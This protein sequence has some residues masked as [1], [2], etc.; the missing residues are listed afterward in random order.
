M[1]SL[2]AATLLAFALVP[3]VLGHSWIYQLRTLDEDGQY[4]G[5]YGYPRKFVAAGDPNFDGFSNVH[6]S[7]P[8]EQQPP[9]INK[10][11]PLCRDD[12][13]K[14]LQNDKYPRL[15]ANPGVWMSLRYAENGHTSNPS[16]LDG[17][18]PGTL[19]LGRRDLGGNVFIFGTTEPR[20]DEKIANVIQWTKDGSGGDKR[21]V[22]LAANDFDDGRCFQVNDSPITK[23]R[24]AAT[25][26]YAMGQ[27]DGPGTYELLCESN[28]QL[29]EDAPVGKP[30]TLY[31]VWQWAMDPVNKTSNPNPTFPNGKDE[32]YTTCMDV[33]VVDTIKLSTKA[34]FYMP[35]Q[36]TMDRAVP[37]FK[38]RK[39][40]IADPLEAEVGNLWK[41]NP[42]QTGA[43]PSPEPINTGIAPP[44]S[45]LSTIARPGDQP[46]KAPGDN[47][48]V[49][50][51]ET[52][53]VT[54]TAT[55]ETQ[56]VTARPEQFTRPNGAK[57]RGRFT[58]RTF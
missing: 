20:E 41:S 29:P 9:F 40:T 12:Q 56:R 50:I 6:L 14:P 23:K 49:T 47:D 15:Q 37:D 3:S 44:R 43:I 39:A 48:V 32:Y 35:Q 8:V 2:L 45:T 13:T 22:L 7:P 36:D 11:N 30:Y 27:M 10:T 58:T 55:A 17:H 53:R 25:K 33:D 16:D 4:V 52:V 1:R 26:N 19:D 28:V 54:V 5:E 31:W 46:T 34:K 24:M 38:S 21:G 18:V 42:S 57:F 51:I